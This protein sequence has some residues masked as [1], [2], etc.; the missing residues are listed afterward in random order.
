[1]DN[2]TGKTYYQG[3]HKIQHGEEFPARMKFP[4][5]IK[6]KIER[7]NEE[8]AKASKP[9]KKVKKADVAPVQPDLGE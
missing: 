5:A 3:G 8:Y 1:M 4:D 9:G 6:E 2:L 7:E